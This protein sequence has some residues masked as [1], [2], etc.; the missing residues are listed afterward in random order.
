MKKALMVSTIMGFMACFERS[1]IKL[2]QDMGYEV[3]I[4]CNV[5]IYASEERLRLLNELNVIKHHIPF[6]R[7]P[8]SK[9][10]ITAYRELSALIKKE[11]FDIVHSHTPVGGVLGRTAAHSCHVPV[12][13]Y[14]AHGFHFF[15]GCPIVNRLLF[16]PIEK[17]MSRWTD[18]LITINNEDYQLARAR[19]HAKSTNRIHGVGIDMDNF[20]VPAECRDAKR[21]ELGL[22]ESEI[23]LISVG[24]LSKDKNHIEVLEAMK[25][26]APKGYKYFIAGRGSKREE[27]LK[28]IKTNGLE[29]AVQL[30]GFREDIP[31]LLRAAD[32]YVFPSL[33]EGV[34]VALMEA[35][36]TKLPVAC[37]EVRGNVDTVITEESYFPVDSPLQLA[38]VVE[39]LCHMTEEE[40]DRLAE[41]NYQNLLKYRLSEVQKEMWEIYTAA[42]ELVEKRK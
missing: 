39:N 12:A 27:Y 38:A 19:F 18:F 24:E 32:I 16:Y 21:A 42:D 11:G 26:L 3:H 29:D 10:N 25:F 13:M 7:R 23:A 17:F 20:V 36:A 15:K 6:T 2:L 1:D 28:F 40:K 37:S 5:N 22:Q 14:T 41:K 30:L 31:E 9:D 4:A 33:V 34:S 35:V 8:I